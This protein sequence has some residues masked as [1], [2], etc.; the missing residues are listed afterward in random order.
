MMTNSACGENAVD[1]DLSAYA[2]DDDQKAITI[3]KFDLP[4]PWI[5][6]L[7]NGNLHAFVSQAAGGFLWWQDAMKGKLTRYRMHNLPIDSPGFYIY[8]RH[9]DGTVWSPSFRPVV[10]P[11]DGWSATHK[12]GTTEFYA[13]KGDFEA[14]LKLFITPDYNALVWNLDIQ[15]KSPADEDVDV[16]AYVELSQYNFLDEVAY[17]YY[18][19]HML[20]TWFDKESDT[21]FYLYHYQKPEN[22]EK[23]PLVFFASTHTVQSYSGDRDAFVGNYRDERDPVAIANGRCGNEEILSGEP[24]AALHCSVSC[25]QGEHARISF[26]LGVQPGVL[27]DYQ[28]AKIKIQQTIQELRKEEII[29]A[30]HEKL[31]A[32]WDNILG[33][34]ECAIPDASAQRQINI[35]SPVNCV[36]VSRYERGVS[37][38][39]AGFREIGFRDTCQDMVAM[40]YRDADLATA[41]FLMLLSLQE[42]AGNAMPR[43]GP[44]PAKKPDLEINSDHHLWLP[45]LAYAVIA[46]TGDSSVLDEIVPYAPDGTQG[47]PKQASVWEHLLAAMRFTADNLGSHGLPLTLKGDWNDIIGKF[48]EQGRGESV[49]AAQQYVC[50]LNYLIEIADYAGKKD[51]AGWLTQLRDEQ[52]ENILACAWNGKWWYRCFDDEGTAIGGEESEFGKI[53]INS[54]TWAVISGVGSR[55]QHE[56]AMKAA[57]HYLSTDVGLMKLYPGFKTWPDVT[58][59]FSGYNPGNGENGAI[60]CHSNTWAII[61]ETMLGNAEQ[62]WKYY[63]QLVPHNALQKMGLEKYKSEPYAWASNIVGVE[64][65]KHG[66]SNVV[67]ITGTA[68]WMDIAATQ[69][70]LGIRARLDGL[71]I[72][73]CIPGW[74]RFSVK[75]NYRGCLLLIDV[76]NPSK[77]SKGVRFVEVDG[78]RFDGGA[79]PSTALVANS[80]VNIKVVMG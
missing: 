10:Q 59:P 40:A 41:K 44:R 32:W 60:F 37:T 77:V 39:A 18:W 52:I 76:V 12:P 19:R 57:N 71:E 67:H 16:F 78:K 63:N 14:T 5:N 3:K 72:D 51:D 35:W 42:S 28:L 46:E 20:K 65:P 61:A 30:Q 55:E 80:T 24:C 13:K 73:P 2:F 48:S 69:Y 25:K 45:F 53:W 43:C 31:K 34:F 4:S 7:S 75:R 26:F 15:N 54:Q 50:A 1:S 17:G 62:A 38:I 68:A 66:W 22:A 6:Y 49:F 56:A 9:K 79:I 23:V 36:Q 70:L 58:H 29:A 8:I 33:K 21:L 74:E 47:P 11:L 27:T 64:N